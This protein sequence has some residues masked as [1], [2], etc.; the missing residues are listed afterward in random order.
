[1]NHDASTIIHVVNQLNQ[2]WVFLTTWSTS[3]GEIFKV[4]SFGTKLQREV[5]L[6]L[7]V[8]EF[9]YNTCGIG[10][11]EQPRQE[12]AGFV[13]SCYFLPHVPFCPSS[14]SHPFLAC[15][16]ASCLVP[17]ASFPSCARLSVCLLQV[18]SVWT[19]GRWC[20]VV[21][22]TCQTTG[23]KHSLTPAPTSRYHQLSVCLS[24]CVC[25]SLCVCVSLCVYLIYHW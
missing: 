10:G 12:P 23:W 20:W 18:V 19:S 6:V 13:Q 17:V 21:V 4:Y 14:L 7:E 1:M 11:R 3:R 15:F 9:P 22:W 16:L 24:V 2:R 5:P 25:L 8:L